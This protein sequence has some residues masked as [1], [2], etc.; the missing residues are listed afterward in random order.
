MTWPPY[1]PNYSGYSILFDMV[2][3]G[4]VAPNSPCGLGYTV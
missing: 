4:A 2:I 3:V 1:H